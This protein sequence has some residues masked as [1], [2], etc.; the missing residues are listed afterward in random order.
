MFQRHHHAL[1]LAMLSNRSLLCAA[2]NAES[3]NKSHEVKTQVDC[4][5]SV[6]E[7]SFSDLAF[8]SNSAPT[9]IGSRFNRFSLPPA[10]QSSRTTSLK[11][12]GRSCCLSLAASVACSSAA[13]AF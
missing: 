8:A 9:S 12:Q 1:S 3:S 11:L 13:V 6:A 10:L 7:S 2:L 4:A 5:D